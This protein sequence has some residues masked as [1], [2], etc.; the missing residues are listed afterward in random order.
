[1]HKLWKEPPNSGKCKVRKEA[2]SIIEKEKAK[3]IQHKQRPYS[4]VAKQ[5]ADAAIREASNSQQILNL[6][7]DTSFQVMVILLHA[8]I[9]NLGNQDHILLR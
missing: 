6:P 5:A 3:Q 4:E 7:D 9:V 8:H 1:M 2:I